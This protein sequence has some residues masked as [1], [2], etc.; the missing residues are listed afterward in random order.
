MK[1]ARWPVGTKFDHKHRYARG[2]SETF[3]YTI[4]DI[5]KTYNDAGALVK[6]QYI[7]HHPYIGVP[8]ESIEND[9]TVAMGVMARHGTL[10]PSDITQ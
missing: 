8:V 5:W 4:I 10:S 1:Q 6:I 7:C 2:K 3:T 9:T